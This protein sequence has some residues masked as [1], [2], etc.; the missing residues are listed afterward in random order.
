MLDGFD[1]DESDY[2]A[3]VAARHEILERL[4]VGQ[5]VVAVEE[6]VPS[7][8]GED[9]LA[10]HAELGIGEDMSDGSLFW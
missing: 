2:L 6:L 3:H 4:V 1:H 10:I 9:V 5:D 7:R 8:G